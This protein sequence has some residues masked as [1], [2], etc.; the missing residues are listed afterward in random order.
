MMN[1][2][3]EFIGEFKV[4]FGNNHSR[5]ILHQFSNTDIEAIFFYVIINMSE[6]YF[7]NFGVFSLF[8]TL[9]VHRTETFQGIQ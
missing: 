7:L 5:L 8:Y 2:E 4:S 1:S 6:Q 3:T 9:L